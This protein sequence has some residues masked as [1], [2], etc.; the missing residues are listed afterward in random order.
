MPGGYIV[1]IVM[2]LMPGKD[3]M[4]LKFWSMEEAQR[5]EIREKFLEAIR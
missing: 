5:K 3:L 1:Y 4:A 2:T